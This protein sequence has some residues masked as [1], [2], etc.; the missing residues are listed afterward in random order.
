[1]KFIPVRWGQRLYLISPIDMI[2]FAVAINSGEE[3]KMQDKSERVRRCH[4]FL[5][6]SDWNKPVFGLPD[7]P[8]PW[9]TLTL[10]VERK[11]ENK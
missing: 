11:N 5:R 1:M 3:P 7:L 4:F 2:D 8:S 6:D 9:K 10:S